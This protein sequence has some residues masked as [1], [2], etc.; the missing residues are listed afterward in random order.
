VCSVDISNPRESCHVA[1][2]RAITLTGEKARQA[3]LGTPKELPRSADIKDTTA[4]AARPSG[5]AQFEPVLASTV[6]E[7]ERQCLTN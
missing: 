5:L 4:K 3:S 7:G 2:V 1:R 6:V